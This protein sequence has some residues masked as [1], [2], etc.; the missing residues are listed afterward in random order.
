MNK[1]KYLITA[2]ILFI[3]LPVTA[4]SAAQAM[5]MSA[6]VPGTGEIYAGSLSKGMLFATTDIVIIFTA[7]RYEKEERGLIDSYK[8]FANAKLGVETNSSRE[9]YD[10]INNWFCSD[11]YNAVVEFYFRNRGMYF[12][13]DPNYYSSQIEQY[14]I[15]DEDA[16]NWDNE[17]DWKKYKSIRKDR[18]KMLMYKKLAIGAAIANRIASALDSYITVRRLNRSFYPSFSIEPD[19]INNSFFLNCSLEF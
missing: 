5:L 8:Q 6:L 3:V 17:R 18:Q 1:L 19:Y 14:L 16:W 7:S 15:S 13:N 9:Y 10:L 12:Y 4:K 2:L 11:E